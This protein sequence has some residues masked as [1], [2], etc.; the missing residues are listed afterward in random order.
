[1]TTPLLFPPSGVLA[2]FD[3]HAELFPGFLETADADT[4]FTS[5]FD[6]T[7]WEQADLIVFGKRATEPRM[8]LWCADNGMDYGYSGSS[9]TAHPIPQV[10]LPVRDALRTTTGADFNSV[11]IN[12]YRDGNDRLGW[13][14]DN[15]ECNGPEPTI[16]SVS[17]GAERRFD[18]RHRESG[19]TVRTLLPHGS[20]LVMS[21]TLQRHWVHQVPQMKSV[22]AP[23]INLTFR[24]VS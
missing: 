18:L 13:H 17:L 7:P 23:R 1:M 12:L 6:N 15:E 8:S 5:L 21:G 20:L 4:L 2:D 19:H 9:R 24:L 22:G 3:G 10:L 11:L 16:A 14:S